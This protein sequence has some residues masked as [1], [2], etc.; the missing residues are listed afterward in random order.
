SL[1]P[2]SLSPSL[3]LSLSL[4]LSKE[5]SHSIYRSQ[6]EGIFVY[7]PDH[8]ANMGIRRSTS[9]RTREDQSWGQGSPL[10]VFPGGRSAR[11]QTE[12]SDTDPQ[13]TPVF[14]QKREGPSC[15]IPLSRLQERMQ[16]IEL[17][18]LARFCDRCHGEQD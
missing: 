3:P 16:K 1:C 5:C 7:W 6:V 9:G 18:N 11:E 13:G 12:P 15:W 8:P 4:S 10:G 2:L 14:P 17:K